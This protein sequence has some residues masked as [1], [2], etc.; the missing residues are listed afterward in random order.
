MKTS[1]GVCIYWP[2]A[3]A[4]SASRLRRHDGVFFAGTRERGGRLR[5]TGGE[6]DSRPSARS[7]SKKEAQSNRF[8]RQDRD[9]VVLGQTPCRPSPAKGRTC[10]PARHCQGSPTT[11]AVRLQRVGRTWWRTPLGGMCDVRHSSQYADAGSKGLP[12]ASSCP[13]APAPRAPL[14]LRRRAGG[15]NAVSAYAVFK[16]T[17]TGEGVPLSTPTGRQVASDY[18]YVMFFEDDRIRHMQKIW[19]AGLAMKEL[20]WI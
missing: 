10:P 16:G 3:R 19:H 6:S 1:M 9:D 20:G 2:H 5:S 13:T 11:A 15:V 8:D 18:V 4:P 12:A 7:L 14:Q 17:H